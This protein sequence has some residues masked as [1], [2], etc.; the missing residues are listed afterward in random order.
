MK[1]LLD[2]ARSGG[3]SDKL[4]SEC[5]NWLARSPKIRLQWALTFSFVSAIQHLPLDLW[6]G[7]DS[8]VQAA[9]QALSHRA[10]CNRATP[11]GEYSAA[12]E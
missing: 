3:H 9:Q 10:T 5:L 2:I 12:M 1:N 4:T 8:N 6:H 7:R 11:R